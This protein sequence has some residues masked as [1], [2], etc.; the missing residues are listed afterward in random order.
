MNSVIRS[1]KNYLALVKFSHTV[2]AM[3][4]ALIGFSVAVLADGYSFSIRLFL[5]V[6]LCMVFARNAAMGFNRYADRK[7]DAM[8]PRTK[9]REIPGGT[10]SSRAALLFVLINA[11]LFI[12]TAGFINKLTLFL[13]P[14]ALIIILGYSLT[15]R[16]TA[17]C[18]FILGLGLSLAPAG[19]YISVTGSFAVVPL[20]YSA[21]VL[22][23]VSGFDIIYAL[24]DDEFD[25]ENKLY[26]LPS[27]TGRKKALIISSAVHALTI[28]L[29]VPAGCLGEGGV[30][31][32]AG[33]LIFV[34]LLVYQH[35]IVKHDDLSRVNIA[36]GTT[37]G[38]ASIFFALF[39]ILDLWIG[40]S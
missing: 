1:V 2:F 17:L 24:Q 26:S 37:N 18:H 34:A 32:W 20:I 7:F 39:V 31:F 23:W 11:A 12:T 29:V 16:F 6:I 38:V 35:K 21:I 13:S 8:N 5:L 10:I 15:K 33:A 19:A 22:T 3:P 40:K 25:S 14:V 27:A 9:Q 4:F 36:F 30:L 28:L